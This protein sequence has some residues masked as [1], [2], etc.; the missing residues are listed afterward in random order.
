MNRFKVKNVTGQKDNTRACD[1]Q[2]TIDATVK[3]AELRYN[4][5]HKA[6]LALRGPGDWEASLQVL[7]STDV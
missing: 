4:H 2:S 1:K 6:V 3:T 5:A 7:R